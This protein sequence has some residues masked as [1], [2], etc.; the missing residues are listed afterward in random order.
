M[1]GSESFP[2]EMHCAVD[3]QL[4][5][6]TQHPLTEDLKELGMMLAREI[7]DEMV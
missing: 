6:I 3:E 1:V 7:I 2:M 4:V 5:F